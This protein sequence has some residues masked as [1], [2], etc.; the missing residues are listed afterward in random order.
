MGK[1]EESNIREAIATDI[2]QSGGWAIIT[3]GSIKTAQGT[4]DII[5]TVPSPNR[6]NQFFLCGIEVKTE[7]GVPSKLQL[8]IAKHMELRGFKV[9]FPH[10]L[11]DWH[12]QFK[13]F[14]RSN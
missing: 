11:Q 5:A 8:K 13:H 7:T 3:S 14:A 4:P 1:K 6:D 9:F 12:T 10:S 2:R